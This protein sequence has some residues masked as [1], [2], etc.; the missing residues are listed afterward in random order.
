MKETEWAKAQRANKHCAS[1]VCRRK[2]SVKYRGENTQTLNGTRAQLLIE[3][4]GERN[5]WFSFYAASPYI[6]I[7]KFLKAAADRELVH[8][9]KFHHQIFKLDLND[10]SLSLSWR[11]RSRRE[12]IFGFAAALLM[13]CA[14][15]QLPCDYI[16]HTLLFSLIAA[17]RSIRQNW[18]P[19]FNQIW[20]GANYLAARRENLSPT[21][22]HPASIHHISLS[23]SMLYTSRFNELTSAF[24]GNIFHTH[25][26]T[27]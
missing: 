14:T 4:V 21:V 27:T 24:W 15:K 6:N 11:C 13:R 9:Q 25:L 3:R 16:M 22:T 17:D 23:N 18:I 10:L 1:D 7:Q 12:S 26:A 19:W 2:C 5:N 20:R 8:S